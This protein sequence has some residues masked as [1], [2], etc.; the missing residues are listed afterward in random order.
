M[1]IEQK[2]KYLQTCKNNLEKTERL[3]KGKLVKNT[4]EMRFRE[5]ATKIKYDHLIKKEI[6]IK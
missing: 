2:L 1:E 3:S 4:L 5:S 6:A